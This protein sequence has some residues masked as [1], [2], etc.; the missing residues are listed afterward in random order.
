MGATIS[1]VILSLVYILIGLIDPP[2]DVLLVIGGWLLLAWFGSA[3][4]I[5]VG[6]ASERYE[7]VEKIWH[8]AAYLIFPLS[9]AA[10][11]VDALPQEIQPYA[12]LIP[13]VNGV[14]M[15]RDGY[16]GGQIQAHYDAMYLVVF[17]L[18]LTLVAMSQMMITS[19]EITPE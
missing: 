18:A 10:Y 16:F 2:E 3:L 6:A 11:L 15:L 19:R 5:A 7:M 12:M 8:P 17:N 14:E 4:A 1:F 13:M 9:G